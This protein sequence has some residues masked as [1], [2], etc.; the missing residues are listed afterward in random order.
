MKKLISAIITTYKR[1]INIVRRAV[2]SVVSQ[3]YYPLELIVVNDNP[4]DML[5]SDAISAMLENYKDKIDIKYVIME[6]SSGACAA[7]N[8]GAKHSHG[9]YLAFLD[10]D[11][12][13][14]KDKLLWQ[15]EKF[16]S[17]KT[18]LVTGLAEVISEGRHWIYNDK[19]RYSGEVLDKLLASNFVRGCSVPLIK[20]DA[21]FSVGGF[22]IRYRA[23]QDLN[24]WI[25]LAK[26]GEFEFV[27]KIL[28]EYHI[29]QN[30]ITSNMNNRIQGW[31]LILSDFQSDFEKHKLSKQR[32]LLSIY[33]ES[34]KIGDKKK[35]TEY[36]K[37][38][39]QCAGISKAYLRST[40][41]CCLPLR[42]FEI[43]REFKRM[44]ATK[45][46][47]SFRA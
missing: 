32:L 11:D 42:L 2:E 24:L 33:E 18:V 23:S 19:E 12:V 21:F 8:E 38:A 45:R 22:D 25:K 15:M 43:L 35:K 10:D 30:S 31:E 40:I 13:W 36:R 5:L 44:F 34:Y 1:P 29:S 9:E 7:R 3:S 47:E 27:E 46:T 14:V 39:Y 41:K 17:E 20:R 16:S 28:V 37:K 6:I 26:L 4:E